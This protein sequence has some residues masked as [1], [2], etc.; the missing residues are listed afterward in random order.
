MPDEPFDWEEEE[1]LRRQAT[2][3]RWYR[4]SDDKPL[5]SGQ[6]WALWDR[7]IAEYRDL[8]QRVDDLEERLFE[9]RAKHFVGDIVSTA[10]GRVVVV[11]IAIVTAFL[12]TN[13]G[14]ELPVP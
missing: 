8:K 10:T 5:L 4:Q 6:F 12:L 13:Y 9:E 7:H 2:G 1:R 14:V 11:I 3:E